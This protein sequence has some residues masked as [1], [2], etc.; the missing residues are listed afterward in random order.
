M[1]WFPPLDAL[2]HLVV[3]CC[4]ISFLRNFYFLKWL[5]SFICQRVFLCAR[6]CMRTCV[7]HQTINFVKVLLECEGQFVPYVWKT[8]MLSA[9]DFHLIL[10]IHTFFFFYIGFSF[11]FQVYFKKDVLQTHSWQ[12]RSHCVCSFWPP[13]LLKALVKIHSFSERRVCCCVTDN[14]MRDNNPSA[15]PHRFYFFDI[16]FGSSAP[17]DVTKGKQEP[18]FTFFSFLLSALTESQ[19]CRLFAVVVS[20][21]SGVTVRLNQRF[22]T[23]GSGAR[24][25]AA[26]LSWLGRGFR[27]F[28]F[29]CICR[30][31]VEQVFCWM[32][33]SITGLSDI[34]KSGLGGFSFFCTDFELI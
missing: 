1:H 24:R 23:G 28:K 12:L 10:W 11:S 21:V 17:C 29:V 4:H 16:N 22:S 19:K 34:T 31:N 25:W 5:L 18:E 14:L 7:F 2:L 30:G 26:D 9:C 6:A 3:A 15:P 20:M 8:L 27:I 32:H 13:S 33:N